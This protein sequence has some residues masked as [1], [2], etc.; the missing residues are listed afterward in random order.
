[1]E[2]FYTDFNYLNY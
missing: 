1:L 2:F